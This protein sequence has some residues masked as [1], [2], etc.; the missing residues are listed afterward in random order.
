MC[1]A[2]FSVPA[3][4]VLAVA[5]LVPVAAGPARA[6]GPPQPARGWLD[7]L[8]Y[9]NLAAREVA[10]LRH[11]EAVEMI[12]A[13]LNGSDMGPGEGWFHPGQG[14]YGWKW[15]ADRYDANQDGVIALREF[16]GSTDDFLR[17]DRDHNGV[18]TA[19][20]FDWSEKSPYMRKI[21]MAQS[22]FRMI[23]RN[24][25]GRV[26]RDEW[27]AF[28][29]K[30]AKEREYITPDD[31]RDALFPAQPYQKPGQAPDEP[32]ALLLLTGLFEGELGSLFP[33]PSLGQEA[34]GF[35]LP[36]EDGKGTIALAELLGKKPIVLVFG[37]FT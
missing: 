15:L 32:P 28:F 4:I 36:R 29:N 6:A 26:S 34:P 18:L 23:D 16:G 12:T 13:V 3:W 20:D 22:W 14:R 21:M 5:C 35:T 10:D 33:G 37:S 19:D 27:E 1:R 24:S 30:M 2:L 9:R 25:N 17:L 31:L 8:R 11:V 7:P